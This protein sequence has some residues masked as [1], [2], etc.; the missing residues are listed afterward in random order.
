MDFDKNKILHNQSLNNK[1]DKQ[2]IYNTWADSYDEYVN[3]MN[4]VAPVELSILLQKYNT[5]DNPE[6]LDFGCGTGLLG[7]VIKNK[8]NC[9]L[10]GIDISDKMIEKCNETKCYDN[11]Y[12]LNLNYDYFDKKY[13]IIVSCGVFLEGHVNINILP[14][15]YKLLNKNG[16]IVFTIRDTFKEENSDDFNKYILKNPDFE[17][18]LYD[19]INYLKDVKSSIIVAKTKI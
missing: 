2:D 12:K 9:I 18:I 19:S 4:Y 6:M 7:V 11:I 15:L 10:D 17:I 1:N 3:S 16:L 5:F 8:I 13:D 14:I